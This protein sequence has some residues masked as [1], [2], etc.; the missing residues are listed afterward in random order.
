MWCYKQEKNTFQDKCTYVIEWTLIVLSEMEKGSK[1]LNKMAFHISGA[2][3]TYKLN[4]GT[5][6]IY[7]PTSYADNENEI[8]NKAT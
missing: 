6:K 8:C 2:V 3:I 4:T 7:L 5:P 1:Y